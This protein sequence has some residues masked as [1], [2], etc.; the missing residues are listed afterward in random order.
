MHSLRR[1]LSP[2]GQQARAVTIN[3]EINSAKSKHR[4]WKR[5]FKNREQFSWNW[6]FNEPGSTSPVLPPTGSPRRTIFCS[7]F[8]C[9]VIMLENPNSGPLSHKSHR[10]DSDFIGSKKRIRLK[11]SPSYIFNN[12]D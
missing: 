11:Q 2:Q 5:F 12:N 8:G 4:V 1:I 3:S 6:A 10:K 9:S 7:S